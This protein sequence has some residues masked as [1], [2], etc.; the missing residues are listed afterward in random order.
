[1]AEPPGISMFLSSWHLQQSPQQPGFEAEQLQAL[2]QGIL[3]FNLLF[4]LWDSLS[5]K[6]GKNELSH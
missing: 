5:I 3:F 2:N 1:M 6:E 4:C